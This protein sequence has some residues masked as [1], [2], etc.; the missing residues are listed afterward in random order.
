MQR[1]RSTRGGGG[2]RNGQ[3]DA[4]GVTGNLETGLF[5]AGGRDRFSGGSGGAGGPTR[6]SRTSRR[7]THRGAASLP[8]RPHVGEDIDGDMKMGGEKISS[9]NPYQRPGRSTRSST[10]SQSQREGTIIVFVST[11]AGGESLATDSGLHD[12]LCRK[13]S[14]VK[15]NISNK[16]SNQ[17]TGAVSFVV[18][19]VVQAKAIRGLSGIRYKGMKL[20]IKT[21]E[22]NKI[23]EDGPQKPV[24]VVQTTG[25]ID[26]IREFIRSR[27]QNGFLNLENMAQDDILRSAKIIPPGSSTGRNDVGAVMMKVAAQLF[28]DIT[29]ISFASNGLRSLAPISSVAQFF[30]NILNLSFKGNEIRSYRDLENLSGAK[31]LPNLREI[32]FLD[33]PLRDRDIAKHKDDISYR[34]EITRLFP[35]IQYL[36]QQPVGPKISF[37][38]GDIVNEKSETTSLPVPIRGNFFDSPDT[39]AMVLEFLTTYFKLFDTNRTLLEHMYDSSATFSVSTNVTISPAQRSKGRGGDNWSEYSESTRNLSRLKDLSDRT[40]RLHVGNQDIVKEGLMPL[41]GTKHDLTD[42]SKFSVDAWQTGS[43]LPAVCIYIM[44]HGEYEQT[45]VRGRGYTKSFDRSFIIAPAP[46]NSSAAQHGWKCLII[47][48]QLTVRQHNG[49]EAWQPEPELHVPG[50]VSSAVSSAFNA[51]GGAPPM[52]DAAIGTTAIAPSPA[53]G[54]GPDPNQTPMEGISPE[55][56]AKA[57]ELQQLTSLNYP[58]SVQCLAAVGWDIQ[59][60]VSLVNQERANIPADAWQAPRF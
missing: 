9:F 22:D 55:Q 26:A 36:D 27:H 60:G 40:K 24:R 33:N 20:I 23:M 48:D 4:P 14:P 57:Q 16:R 5:T 34:S 46:P 37:G 42:A 18:S 6:S 28:P 10:A 32:I 7:G 47:S 3:S 35:S 19:D 12:F 13:A 43:L 54:V 52:T 15:I 59:A 56:H 51:A 30:P 2:G 49:H 1:A 29:T 11:P 17:T 41:P 39:Q 44:V 53:A 8:P 58:Y 21:T 50:T 25:T 45:P 31:K 38:L